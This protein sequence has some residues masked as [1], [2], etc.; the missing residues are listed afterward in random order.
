MK[1]YKVKMHYSEYYFTKVRAENY[2]DAMNK[3]KDIQ[4]QNCKKDEYTDWLVLD[5][6]E[7][8][9]EL[10]KLDMAFLECYSA[11]VGDA[12]DEIVKEYLESEDDDEFFDQHSEYYSSIVDAREMFLMALNYAKKEGIN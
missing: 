10:S 4:M 3:S 9:K 2:E 12:P 6:Q 8:K 1:T 11:A 7:Y 5:I